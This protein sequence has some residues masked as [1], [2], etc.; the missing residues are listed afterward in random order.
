MLLQ[1]AFEVLCKGQANIAGNSSAS[2][3]PH[4]IVSPVFQNNGAATCAAPV[5]DDTDPPVPLAL[6]KQLDRRLAPGAP[7]VGDPWWT[8][9]QDFVPIALLKVCKSLSPN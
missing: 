5:Q 8:L 1:N 6:A 2:V 3:A 7:G 9:M 4:S